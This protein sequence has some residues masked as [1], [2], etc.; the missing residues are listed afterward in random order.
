MISLYKQPIL[1]L[2]VPCSRNNLILS[3]VRVGSILEELPGNL[4]ALSFSRINICEICPRNTDNIS[5]CTV[6]N[7]VHIENVDLFIGC[8]ISNILTS[9]TIWDIVFGS[10]ATLIG[11]FGTYWLRKTKFIF[12]LPPV[13]ANMFVVPLVLKL[14][15][16][17]EDAWWFLLVTIGIGEIISICILGYLL[18]KLL[19]KYCNV[20][21]RMDENGRF[22]EGKKAV[23]ED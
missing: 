3:Y 9:A 23:K 13:V 5:V 17:L 11:A 10:L 19:Y 2:H 21:F 8:V 1:E 14:A 16:G 22:Y 12:T 7:N 4:K 20:I 6:V 15:L 18:S